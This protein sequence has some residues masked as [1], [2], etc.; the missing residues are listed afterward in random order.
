M[1]GLDKM[2]SQI[3]EEAKKEAEGCLEAAEKKAES[4]MAEEMENARLKGE[5]YVNKAAEEAARYLERTQALAERKHRITLLQAKQD[6]IDGVL[7]KAY[8]RLDHL[9]EKEYFAFISRLLRQ[10]VQPLEGEILFS[11]RDRERL[12]AGFEEKI[13]EIAEEKGGTLKLGNKDGDI[14]NGFILVYGGIEENCTFRALF[15]SRKEI[16]KDTVRRILFP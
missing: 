16:L 15:D 3:E 4:L 1:T 13:T 11:K 10:Y 12:P 6:V 7:K 8:E 2:I 5:A 14:E 9:D